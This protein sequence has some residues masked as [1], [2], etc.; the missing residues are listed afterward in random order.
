MTGIRTMRIPHTQTKKRLLGVGSRAML[1]SRRVE[2]FK[3]LRLGEDNLYH[4]KIVPK[5]RASRYGRMKHS[6]QKSKYSSQL[7]FEIGWQVKVMS[8]MKIGGC[9]NEDTRV[10]RTAVW[11]SQCRLLPEHTSRVSHDTNTRTNVSTFLA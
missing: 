6:L 7:A 3:L 9:L 10:S 2:N 4:K 8:R 5:N 11:K 1:K